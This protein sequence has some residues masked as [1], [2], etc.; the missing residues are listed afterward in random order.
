MAKSKSVKKTTETN[1]ITL[2]E[3]GKVYGNL[4]NAQEVS[5]F[6][7]NEL[8]KSTIDGMEYTLQI[9]EFSTDLKKFANRAKKYIKFL[10]TA[11][12][13]ENLDIENLVDLNEKYRKD[14]EKVLM[15]AYTF[16]PNEVKNISAMNQSKFMESLK[17]RKHIGTAMNQI[18]ERLGL[19]SAKLLTN[20]K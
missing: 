13:P 16:T 5:L 19:E 14:T 20:G 9:G 10:S 7:I 17:S 2:L 1:S 8:A 6:R 11:I 15:K 12:V 18:S 3:N 4:V